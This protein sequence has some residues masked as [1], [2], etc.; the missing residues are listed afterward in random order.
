[1][2]KFPQLLPLADGSVHTVHSAI[3]CPRMDKLFPNYFRRYQL[4]AFFLVHRFCLEIISLFSR[5]PRAVA[6]WLQHFTWRDVGKKHDRDLFLLLFSEVGA[7]CSKAKRRYE[8]GSLFYVSINAS[9][10]CVPGLLQL[11]KSILR[12]RCCWKHWL[13]EGDDGATRWKNGIYWNYLLNRK[14]FWHRQCSE[15]L[16][17]ERWLRS[18]N[19][20]AQFNLVEGVLWLLEFPNAHWRTRAHAVFQMGMYT[21]FSLSIRNLHEYS[22]IVQIFDE[23]D[24]C[25]RFDFIKIN[26]WQSMCAPATWNF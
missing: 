26:W 4:T 2:K 1:M 15:G 17:S 11:I 24:E 20:S 10:S 18:N 25:L 9:A 22:A 13:C 3:K 23:C 14:L 7:E 21:N 12:L 6:K 19:T 8:M 5:S 16:W